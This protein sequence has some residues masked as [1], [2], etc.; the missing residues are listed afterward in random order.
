M[1]QAP[2]GIKSGSRAAIGGG[3]LDKF[4]FRIQVLLLLYYSQ[5]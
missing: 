3:A 4:Q 2:A 1:A 5:A